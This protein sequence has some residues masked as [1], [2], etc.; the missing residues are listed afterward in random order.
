MK[1]IIIIVSGIF[2]IGCS[3]KDCECTQQKWERKATYTIVD[4]SVIPPTP[5]KLISATEWQKTGNEEK[6]DNDDCGRNGSV[7]RK[8]STG[9]STNINAGTYTNL[10]FEYRITCQ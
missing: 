4:T 3:G 6:F 5:P 1:K 9:L 10:E 2:L 8:G 7:G